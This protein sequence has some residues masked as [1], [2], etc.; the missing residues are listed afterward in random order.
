[1]LFAQKEDLEPFVQER[2]AV[3]LVGTGGAWK[4]FEDDTALFPDCI[5]GQG[6]HYQKLI[7]EVAGVQKEACNRNVQEI[8]RYYK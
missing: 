6:M 4:Y 8:E 5:V 7:Q 3:F 2:K 1:M